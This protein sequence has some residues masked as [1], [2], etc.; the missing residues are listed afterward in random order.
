MAVGQRLEGFTVLLVE[1]ESIVSMLAEDVLL[2]AGCS[3]L[4]AMRLKEALELA[5]TAA[6]HIAVLDVNLG[7]GDTSYPVADL[8]I[9]RAIPFMFATGYDAAGLDSRFSDRPRIQKPYTPLNLLRMASA[10][11]E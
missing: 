3:V 9:K 7:G 2:D 1:D 11:A 6:I 4:L 10:I 5:A 8:L